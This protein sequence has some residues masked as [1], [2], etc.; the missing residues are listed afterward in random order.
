MAQMK[1]PQERTFW[2]TQA[3]VLDTNAALDWLHFNDPGSQAIAQAILT[4]QVQWLACPAMRAEYAHVVRRDDIAALRGADA[5]ALLAAWDS[6]AQT[7]PDPYTSAGPGLRCTDV[8]DQVFIDFALEHRCRWLLT[9]DKA[10]LRLA[11]RAR[12]THGLVILTP[13]Q[14]AALW[15]PTAEQL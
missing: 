5:Q 11:R 15:V 12:A 6:A 2:Q 1:P 7:R 13:R 10:L 14:F 8:D 3:V 4:R 9:H